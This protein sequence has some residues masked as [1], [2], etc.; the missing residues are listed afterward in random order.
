MAVQ[1]SWHALYILVLYVVRKKLHIIVAVLE[2]VRPEV[3]IPPDFP[4]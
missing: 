2:L 4:I 3:E 1:L